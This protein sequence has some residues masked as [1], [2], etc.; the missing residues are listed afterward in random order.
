[1]QGSAAH[2]LRRPS[3]RRQ[4][5]RQTLAS[6]IALTGLLAPLVAQATP[7]D[8]YYERSVMAAANQ[9]CG[10]FTPEL[11]SALESAQAQARGAALR[12]GAS[13]FDL[14]ATAA[15]ARRKAA[16][17][18]CGS[19]DL[20]LA[21]N[22]VRGAFE[23]YAHLLRMTFP[24]DA[25]SWRADRTDAQR[26]YTWRL[27]QMTGFGRDSLAFGLAGRAGTSA[28]IASAAF[29]D[30]AQPYGARLV[31]RDVTRVS[32]P[33]LNGP[34]RA[35]LAGRLPPRSGD[36]TF[37]A[38]ARA[39]ADLT[40]LPP[41]TRSGVAF[42]FPRAATE[43]LGGL[44]PREAVAVEFL[45]NGQGRDTQRTAYVEVGDFAAGRA[46]LAASQR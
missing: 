7:V 22:R 6:V 46:F 2:G 25:S 11:S 24:G 26:A 41:G 8:L 44:D 19:P 30:G 17:T 4:T 34:A 39:D 14:N 9:R 37:L 12:A 10:L 32:G 27:V 20:A 21:A 3:R 35:S 13:A 36:I 45:F 40:L 15:Q 38:E 29:A 5:P 28:L 31:L 16:V 1:M 18:L 23:S 43:A 33:S 42:R